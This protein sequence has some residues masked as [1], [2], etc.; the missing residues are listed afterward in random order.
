MLSVVTRGLNVF[1][2]V[3][4]VTA[5][6]RRVTVAYGNFRARA[7]RYVYSS[8]QALLDVDYMD[9]T[10]EKLLQPAQP[11]YSNPPAPRAARRGSRARRAR[12][13]RAAGRGGPY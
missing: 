13:G 6:G 1:E 10:A 5:A 9:L 12:R 2:S 11:A 3:T 4:G 8:K 7:A